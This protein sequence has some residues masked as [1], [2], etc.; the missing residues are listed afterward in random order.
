MI[1]VGMGALWPKTKGAPA[2]G[3]SFRLELDLGN[4]DGGRTI[5]A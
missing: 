2:A 3:L 1:P 5:S 4:A